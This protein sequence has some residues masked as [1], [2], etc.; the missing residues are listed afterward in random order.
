[1]TNDPGNPKGRRH[2]HRRAHE[3][4][5]T[6][7]HEH[8][9]GDRVHTHAHG[10]AHAHEHEHQHAHEHGSGGH[11]HGDELHFIPVASD[12]EPHSHEELD[13]V[14]HPGAPHDHDH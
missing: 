14:S 2:V 7:E 10:H 6:H 9:H 11:E 4:V 8:R 1:M 12:H 3:H 13:G 5:H